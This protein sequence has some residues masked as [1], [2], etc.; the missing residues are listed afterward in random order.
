MSARAAWTMP[1]MD[2]G[3]CTPHF[4]ALCTC[5]AWD[6]WGV[7]Y[8]QNLTLTAPCCELLQPF[9]LD[10]STSRYLANEVNSQDATTKW[11]KALLV[12]VSSEDMDTL[13][14]TGW[15]VLHMSLDVVM[16]SDMAV[17]WW[18][19]CFLVCSYWFTYPHARRSNWT[20]HAT[21]YARNTWTYNIS[22][23]TTTG[24]LPQPCRMYTEHMSWY[25]LSG[26]TRST[27]MRP[28]RKNA[29]QPWGT[30]C[31]VGQT[32]GRRDSMRHMAWMWKKMTQ[33]NPWENTRLKCLY[34]TN[35]SQC[36]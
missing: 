11:P 21:L 16:S 1:W 20:H 9:S 19:V 8:K 18:C 13:L 35:P 2:R 14:E 36:N 6:A 7:R 34:F 23:A 29:R 10:I 4:N 22:A 30:E 27:H 32:V 5:C 26:T 3:S 33:W 25:T 31:G 24:V 28:E 12:Q 15:T 17:V